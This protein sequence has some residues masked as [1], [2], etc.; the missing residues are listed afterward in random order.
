M[1]EIKFRGKRTKDG[2]WVYGDLKQRK[3]GDFYLWEI[4]GWAINTDTVG[5]FT[6][7]YDQNKKEIYEGDILQIR[8]YE[9]LE[10]ENSY[11]E[12]KIGDIYWHN[13]AFHMR[14]IHAS[15]SYNN[16]SEGYT[17]IDKILSKL[18]NSNKGYYWNV[19]CKIIGNIHDNPTFIKS[20]KE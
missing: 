14:N 1:R 5:Q 16:S 19:E 6:D 20:I 2:S 17:N 18:C 11:K 9:F 12:P 15:D 8:R 7:F 10:N 4:D 3:V 13:G